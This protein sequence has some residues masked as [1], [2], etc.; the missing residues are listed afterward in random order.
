MATQGAFKKLGPGSYSV[1]P[2]KVHKTWNIDESMIGEATQSDQDPDIQ[3]WKGELSN[4]TTSTGYVVEPYYSSSVSADTIYKQVR[5]LY[6]GGSPHLDSVF[7]FRSASGF[8]RPMG[9]DPNSVGNGA[10]INEPFNT[11]GSNNNS[12]IFL[13]TIYTN[14]K[15]F[16]SIHSFI[17][18]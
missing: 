18:F 15:F 9:L 2:F 14:T 8:P 1:Y 6:Y 10:R 3:V 5:H 11:F 12:K 4:T 13:S 16:E 7:S 17:S